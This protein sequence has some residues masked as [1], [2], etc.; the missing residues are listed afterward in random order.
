MLNRIQKKVVFDCPGNTIVSASPGSGKTKTL[1]ARAQHKLETIQPF[2]ALALITYTNAGADEISDR[3]VDNEKTLF[4]GT[5]HRF[6]LEFILRPY[7]WIYGWSKPRIIT[8]D[9][10]SEF[11]DS[12]K[13][14][15]FGENKIESIGQFKKNIKGE[16]DT[17][18]RWT[19]VETFTELFTLYNNFLG[20]KKAIDFNE[21]LYRSYKIVSENDFVVTSL[22]NKFYEISVDEFQDTNIFQYEIF[23]IINTKELCTFFLVGD[24]KQRILRFAGAIDCAF[25]SASVDF[26]TPVEVLEEVYRSTTNIVNAYCSL[27][28][29]HP[30]L[31]NQSKYNT[32][33]TKILI[34]ET[35][36]QTHD[37]IIEEIIETLITKCSASPNDIA[38]LSPTWRDCLQVSKLLRSKYKVKGFGA[39]P[40]KSVGNSTFA[41]L[42][43][44]VKFIYFGSIR[45][46]RIVRRNVEM[47]LLENSLTLSESEFHF[48]TNQLISKV[49]EVVRDRSLINGI[50]D[51]KKIFESIFQSEHSAFSELIQLI[52]DEEA[53]QWSIERYFEVL[54]G[55]EGITVNTIH[56]SKGLEYEIVILNQINENKIPYQKYL[57]KIQGEYCY[58]SLTEENTQD[59]KT[60][61]YVGISRA[62]SFLVVLH[63]FKPSMFID[64]LKNCNN[65]K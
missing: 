61:F 64:S 30:K 10:L 52:N 22:A 1:V 33:D 32:I 50:L 63:G 54:A 20:Q 6:C 40:H 11:L 17:S 27:F 35:R 62:M 26:D 28:N 16:L 60:L 42:R 3:L 46:L 15:D 4:I 21:I 53:Q 31:T 51:L 59:G 8:F 38:I 34:R 9:E 7:G 57:G 55:V 43:A 13:D 5:I 48:R 47:H 41:L 24:P 56:Q 12:N 45:N 44:V 23:K 39:F 36:K 65:L 49:S 25:E 18:N 14:L 29:N 37:Q 19:D 58:E 2:K